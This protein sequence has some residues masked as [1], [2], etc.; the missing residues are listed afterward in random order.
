M[1]DDARANY[2]V[3]SQIKFKTT[4][5]KSSLCDYIDVHILVKGNKIISGAGTDRC[6]SKKFRRKK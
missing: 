2:G 6:S 4:I 5:L 1:S 3:N